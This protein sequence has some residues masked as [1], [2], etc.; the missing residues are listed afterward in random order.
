MCSPICAY[1]LQCV[2][3]FCFVLFFQFHIFTSKDTPFLHVA[4]RLRKNNCYASNTFN[5]THKV[6]SQLV[7]LLY[8]LSNI[9]YSCHVSK[10]GLANQEP[11][12][13]PFPLCKNM[14][15]KL[16]LKVKHNDGCLVLRYL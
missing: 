15:H 7:Y 12:P 13:I 1:D 11:L 8:E 16:F 14:G 5:L 9:H 3:C 2:G 4:V 6:F 10:V